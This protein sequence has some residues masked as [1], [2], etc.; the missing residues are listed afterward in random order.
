M[1][2]IDM[3]NNYINNLYKVNNSE[4]RYKKYLY[5][6][7]LKYL[8]KYNINKYIFERN[9]N[10]DYSLSGIFQNN[11]IISCIIPKRKSIFDEIVCIHELTRL[12]NIL[13]SNKNN[14]SKYNEIIPYFNEYDYLKNIN[15]IYAKSYELYRLK[16]LFDKL[17]NNELSNSHF[18][19]YLIL[20]YR[21]NNYDINE[22]N[23][24]NSSDVELEKE[25]KLKEYTI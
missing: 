20:K 1:K 11:N 9:L 13:S 3:I 16:S 10:N 21:E 19:A 25:L 15:E 8:K 2:N 6:N 23:K 12:V 17:N 18:L 24:I 14:D 4:E 7:V 5:K 22:L